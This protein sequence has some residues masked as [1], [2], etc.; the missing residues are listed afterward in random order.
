[1]LHEFKEIAVIA[2][3]DDNALVRHEIARQLTSAGY[4]VVQYS[5]LA[6]FLNSLNTQQPLCVIVDFRTPVISAF[7]VQ[8]TLAR[9]GGDVPV[10]VITAHHTPENIALARRLGAM[11]CLPKPVQDVSLL[12]AVASALSASGNCADRRQCFAPW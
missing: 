1:L 3:V 5:L 2:V 6:E 12:D 4:D 7:H 10:I 11:A 9:C 8:D